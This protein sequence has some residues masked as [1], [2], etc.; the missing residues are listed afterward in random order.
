MKAG[1]IIES[2]INLNGQ[3]DA[4]TWPSA[5]DCAS[6]YSLLL[7]CCAIYTEASS[8]VYSTN[9]FFIR[10]RDSRSLQ[11]LRNL[12]PQSLALLTHLTVHLN[13]TSCEKGDPCW[14]ALP[15]RQHRS[16]RYDK[17]LRL[18]PSSSHP[19]LSEWRSTIECIRAHLKPSRLK[20]HFVCDVVDIETARQVA[21]PLLSIPMLASCDIRL[22]RTPDPLI[23]QLARTTAMRAMGYPSYQ[24]ESPFRILDLPG[25]LRRQI[26]EFTDLV[27][28]LCETEWSPLEGFRLRYSN[29]RCGGVGDCEPPLHYACQFRNCWEGSNDGC[30]CRHF[31]AAFTPRCHCWSPPTS[32]FLVCRAVLEDARAVFFMRNRFVIYHSHDLVK[33]PPLRLEASIF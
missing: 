3:P 26:F 10:Y 22:S 20:L 29:W 7:S 33:H 17:P 6:S 27:T 32:L 24:S 19:I 16:D 18:S 5:V 31:H 23:R 1:L 9:R 30:F 2:D 11:P 28:P 8:A 13:V 21:L 25:E 14:K 15:G 4:H 12:T